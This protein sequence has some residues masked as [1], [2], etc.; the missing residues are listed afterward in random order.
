MRD[1]DAPQQGK[2]EGKVMPIQANDP[3]L[4]VAAHTVW[5]RMIEDRSLS[6]KAAC[7]AVGVPRWQFYKALKSD[8]VQA[9]VSR[10]LDLMRTVEA[11]LLKDNWFEV[12]SYQL[13]IAR[14][15]EG[16]P[17]TAVQ[18]ARFLDGIRQRAEEEFTGEIEDPEKTT[19]FIRQFASMPSK[20]KY[21]A[22]RTRQT[23]RGET[24][25]EELTIE[26][27]ADEGDVIDG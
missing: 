8:V 22:S 26:G 18:A 1:F 12:V 27:A 9:E 6:V 2:E 17:R 25:S 19:D 16:D 23:G 20:K 3:P 24:L 11:K 15:Q 14:G 13:D 4:V 10:W 5:N 21:K 7:E